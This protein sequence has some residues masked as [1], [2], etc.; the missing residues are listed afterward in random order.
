MGVPLRVLVLGGDGLIGFKMS[1]VLSRSYETA[2]VIRAGRESPSCKF[3][4]SYGQVYPERD[5][6]N[7]ESIAR[8]LD[9]FKPDCAVNCLGITRHHPDY[10][11][12]NAIEVNSLFPHRLQA[13]CARRGTRLIHLSTDCV[14]SGR[15]GNYSEQDLPDPYD[16]YG[17]SKLLGEVTGPNVLTLRTS[18]VGPELESGRRAGLFEWFRSR[19]GAVRGY[20]RAIWSGLTTLELARLV[21]RLVVE[22]SEGLFHVG[23]Q[24]VDKFELL[25]AFNRLLGQGLPIEEDQTFCCDRSLDSTRFCHESGYIPPN[26]L[27][28]VED[29]EAFLCA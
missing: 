6:R 29:K 20:R 16:L 14:F 9:D 23:G 27:A 5:A 7:R 22:R 21:T 3:L 28:M 12:L 8:V 10:E 19:S 17:R 4:S 13:W 24:A 15:R 11:P 2:A 25:S 26:W 18:V 1:Q